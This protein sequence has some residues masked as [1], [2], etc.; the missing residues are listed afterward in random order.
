MDSR[1]V[2]GKTQVL[3]GIVPIIHNYTKVSQNPNFYVPL[4][5]VN[6]KESKEFYV[7][8][9]KYLADQVK[10]KCCL[11]FWSKMQLQN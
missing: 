10:N 3:V 7:A 9:K 5:V 8:L 6:S 2:G 11:F 4:M 1:K